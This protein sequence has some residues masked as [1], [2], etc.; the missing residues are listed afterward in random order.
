[1]EVRSVEQPTNSAVSRALGVSVVAPLST[2][3]TLRAD[4]TLPPGITILFGASGAGKSTLLDCIAGL[5]K[6][7][8]GRIAVGPRVL[9]DSAQ[10]V[11][12]STHARRAGYLFQTLALF[13]HLSA[14][15]NVAYGLAAIPRHERHQRAAA[16]LESFHVGHLTDKRPHQISG[17]ERQRVALARALVTDPDFLLLDEPLSGLDA[18]TKS[19]ILDDLRAWNRQHQ[20]PIVYVTHDR[21]EVTALGER[22]V[23]LEKGIV[24]AEGQ[25]LDVL[26]APVSETV[27]QLAGFENIFDVTVTSLHAAQGSMTCQLMQ[28]A[29]T[30]ETP[31]SRGGEGDHL[32]LGVRAGDILVATERPRNISARNILQG[33]VTS[34]EHGYRFVIL[35]VNCGTLFEV[36]LTS[37]AVESLGLR[38]QMSVWLLIKTHSCH[39]LD[40][41]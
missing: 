31:L 2:E 34:I 38:E 35:R 20:I 4:I 10:R 11:N 8:E 17:G 40:R 16:L 24:I 28:S 18:S 26:N 37:G 13:P 19:R 7:A 29:V 6:P 25:P 21:E 32:R 41:W 39:L 36:H 5:V 12:I 33:I 22:V 14:L 27:A 23:V 3:F 1:M 15:R 30:L 9:F